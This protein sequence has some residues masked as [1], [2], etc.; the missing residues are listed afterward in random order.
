MP[1]IPEGFAPTDQMP[2]APP[3]VP[4]GFAPVD[5]SLPA[6]FAP[7]TQ[8][9]MS[10]EQRA[11]AGSGA[12]ADLDEGQLAEM[13]HPVLGQEGA[14]EMAGAL[15]SLFKVGP[16]IA[17][18]GGVGRG[19]G[20]VVEEAAPSIRAGLTPAERASATDA[21]VVPSGYL[22]GPSPEAAPENPPAATAAPAP[23]PAAKQ[24]LDV[25][26][27]RAKNGEVITGAR[28]MEH[29]DIIAE[30][31][32]LPA[33]VEHGFIDKNGQ[34]LTR[35]Q[36]RAIV[37]AAIGTKMGEGEPDSR[38]LFPQR[39]KQL[40]GPS[41]QTTRYHG[42]ST[43]IDTLRPDTY[44]TQNIYGQG[45]YTTDN[46]D[47]AKGYSR[48][49]SG[50]RPSIYNVSEKPGQNLLNLDTPPPPAVRD[51][52]DKMSDLPGPEGELGAYFQENPDATLRDWYDDMRGLSSEASGYTADDIQGSF[53]S[54]QENL[55]QMGYQ[56]LTHVGGRNTGKAPHT[57][58][59]YFNPAQSLDVEGTKPWMPEVPSENLMQRV[60]GLAKPE[61]EPE[62]VPTGTPLEDDKTGKLF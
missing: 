57:V 45:F 47:I 30:H 49:G 55:E 62:D 11:R 35:P 32:N 48:K 29:K 17:A 26:A 60:I 54:M 28:G 61:V 13:L 51:M 1:D 23:S 53:S 8:E 58:N 50:G 59:I 18:L 52:V 43:P 4:A 56:G 33:P 37:N 9:P 20:G 12:I 44:S 39:A 5:H 36:A 25:P 10:P 46:Y 3:P 34:F 41:A 15:N 27:I 14:R 31:P 40:P 19:E 42:T 16:Y 6:G 38:Q 24:V 22:E 21:A 2:G 7:T